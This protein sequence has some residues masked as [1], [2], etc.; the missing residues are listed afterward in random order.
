M[1][2]F[3]FFAVVC[4][5]M[6]MGFG[7]ALQAQTVWNGTADVSWYDATQTSFDISTPEQ[8]AGVAQLVNNGTTNFNGVTL[9]LANDIWLNSTG[10]STN[11]WVPI[12]GGSP[13]GESPNTGNA[14]KGNFNGHGHSIYNL[15]CDK[16]N[17]F[18]AGLFCALE[19]PCTIDS[20]VLIN[21]VLKSR[22]MMGC[23]T[24][25]VRGSGSVYIRNCLVVNVRIEGV[26]SSGS[27]NIGAI[28]GATYPSSGSIYFQ[29]LGSTGYIRGY[30]PAGMSGNAE[31]GYF[32]NC[33]FAGSLYSYGTNFGGMAGHGGN[34]TNC[35][36]YT[37]VLS[38]TNQSTASSDGI[39]VTQT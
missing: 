33:Y 32:T 5:T 21:P 15:Y 36:S 35:Y 25:Y 19:S 6:L 22:G 9:N 38:S 17:T 39:A 1:K 2:R 18:H 11:N 14:F 4:L 27:N 23:I 8:L 29:N 30:Y 7:P 12:G 37:N 28:C 13:T 24:G 16:G 10:D 26:N 20:L 3:Y 34:F 31:R